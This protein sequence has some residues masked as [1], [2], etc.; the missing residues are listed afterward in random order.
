[1]EERRKKKGTE[2]GVCLPCDCFVGLS[3]CA[4]A[5]LRRAW[6]LSALVE[7]CRCGAQAPRRS[8]LARQV[9]R[10]SSLQP[11]QL[12]VSVGADACTAS[13]VLAVPR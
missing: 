12:Q 3:E 1:M 6:A 4:N 7:R 2:K 5:I 8:F 10:V 9:A 13:L 11:T